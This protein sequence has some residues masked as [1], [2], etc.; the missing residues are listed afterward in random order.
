MHGLVL[1]FTL[2]LNI[3]IARGDTLGG[4]AQQYHTSVA[5]IMR[6]NP[7]IH[8]PDKILSG[9]KL[10]LRGFPNIHNTSSKVTRD[11]AALSGKR[12]YSQPNTSR[13][14]SANGAVSRIAGISPCGAYTKFPAS[15]GPWVVPLDCFG[16]IFY[17]GYGDC[18]GWVRHNFPSLSQTRQVIVGDA[19]HFPA[20]RDGAGDRGHWG[21]IVALRGDGWSIITEENMY[22]R[23]GGFNRV[24]YRFILL[25][26]DL[27]Y[28][29]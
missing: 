7:N 6:D 20:G 12:A 15:I 4:I 5:Q 3:T 19:I 28:Y 26:P 10:T 9:G 25:T 2:F 27:I 23:G 24:N 11:N 8:N 22:W 16:H 14:S 21:I 29:R 13:Q 18:Y 17:T 1:A